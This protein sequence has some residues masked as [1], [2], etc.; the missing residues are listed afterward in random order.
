MSSW[1]SE[2]AGKA[3]NILNKID[4]NAAN[5]LKTESNENGKQLDSKY[6][7]NDL[8]NQQN[9]LNTLSS[10]KKSISA[11]SLI[12]RTP[13][14]QMEQIIF[15]TESKQDE[16]KAPAVNQDENLSVNWSQSRRSSCS[17]RTEGVQTVIECPIENNKMN[18]STYSTESDNPSELSAMKIVLAEVKA[19]REAL[20]KELNELKKQ[21][22]NARTTELIASLEEVCDRLTRDNEALNEK[23]NELESNCNSYLQTI[24]ELEI[25][26]A[27]LRESETEIS[28]MLKISQ[29]ENDRTMNELQQYRVRA[30]H[31]LQA[32]DELIAE[33]KNARQQSNGANVDDLDVHM[34]KTECSE[35]RKE[36]DSLNQELIMFRNQ[37]EMDREQIALLEQRRREQD[38]RIN[39]LEKSSS[40][41]LKEENLRVAQ[42]EDALNIQ[43][44]ELT[45]A[46]EEMKNQQ[47]NYQVKLHEK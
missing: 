31:T 2:L 20:Q 15:I 8:E 43:S 30:Q 1:F 9:E 39:F 27:K 29:T 32:K 37:I 26:V 46:R 25:S 34:I 17:S 33:L 10:I 21:I 22:A 41:S 5:V 38:E 19:D 7:M 42:L 13:K 11:N 47:K 44:K 12:L 24:S 18:I 35:L 36:R 14:K 40:N 45:A 4:Q 28:E 6:K 16:D 23:T 3:E